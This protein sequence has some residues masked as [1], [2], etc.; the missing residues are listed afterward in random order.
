MAQ[1]DIDIDDAE[2]DDWADR[3]IS[4]FTADGRTTVQF[5]VKQV[6][7]AGSQRLAKRDRPFQ[8]GAKLDNVGANSDEFTLSLVFHNNLSEPGLSGTMAQWPDAVEE[9][10]E[11][12]HIG[13]TGALN[14]PW[15][16]GIRC[17]ADSWTRIENA[18]DTRGGAMV[19]VKFVTDNED[20][21]DR[22]A[23][24]LVSVRSQSDSAVA[25]ASFDADS[26]NM[27]DGSIEDITGFAADLVGLL[28][29]PN[30]LLG[31]VLA[32]AQ[33]VQRAVKF[34][35]A[36]F[37]TAVPGRDHMNDPDSSVARTRLLEIAA[38]AAQAE[39]DALSALPATVTIVYTWPTDI[40][41]VAVDRLVASNLLI[42]INDAIPDLSYIDAG[43]P[44]KVPA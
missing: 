16:R 30:E 32:A 42:E 34:L 1:A 12:F 11:Q 44:I 23:F 41:S 29:S 38:M 21:L 27:F 25:Q 28:N 8:R 37:E 15:K 35:V 10:I 3:P 13:E 24:Q 43:T 19:N 22:D 7:E 33:R 18:D 6:Q 4:D 2:G 9:L 39:E 5:L 26:I 40:W 36:G 20:A 31:T 17:K 14:L